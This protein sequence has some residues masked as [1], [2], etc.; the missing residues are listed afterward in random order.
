MTDLKTR[1]TLL[2]AL[3][4]AAKRP[5]NEEELRRQRVS[6]IMGTLNMDSTITRDQVEDILARHEGRKVSSGDPV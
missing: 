2:E 3:R 5:M 6:F 4:E 1:E